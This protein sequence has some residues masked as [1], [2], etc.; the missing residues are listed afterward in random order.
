M[1]IKT[2]KIHSIASV[3]S[4]TLLPK[5]LVS[6]TKKIFSAFA[7]PVGPIRVKTV[8]PQLLFSYT[9]HITNPLL[10]NTIRTIEDE[11]SNAG[12]GSMFGWDAFSL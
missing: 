9:F 12:S 5:R 7:I 10:S 11:K 8:D 3:P 2:I 4:V 6:E 1:L